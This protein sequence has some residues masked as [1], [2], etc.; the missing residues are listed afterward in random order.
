MFRFSPLYVTWECFNSISSLVG[1]K[2]VSSKLFAPL[3]F[4]I[5]SRN[6]SGK[7]KTLYIRFLLQKMVLYN[8]CH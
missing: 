6:L 8:N 4:R 1:G 3:N 2:I 7:Y 5:N